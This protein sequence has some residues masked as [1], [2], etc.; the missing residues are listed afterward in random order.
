M[1]DEQD[2]NDDRRQLVGAIDLGFAVESALG[3]EVAKMLIR[4]SE[5]AREAA[6]EELAAADPTDVRAITRAQV[7]VKAID[8]WQSWMAEAIQEGR[9]AQRLLIESEQG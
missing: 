8:F 6:L 3:S 2:R 9:Q 5:E 4:R 7:V 1:S